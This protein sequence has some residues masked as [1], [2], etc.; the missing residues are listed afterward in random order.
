MPKQSRKISPPRAAAQPRRTARSGRAYPQDTEKTACHKAEAQAIF[1]NAKRM[2][3]MMARTLG[4]FC[5]VAVHDFSDLEHSIIHIEGALTGR[6]V[7]APATNMVTKAWRQG[8][9]NVQD[10][11]AYSAAT[12]SGRTLKSSISFLR[13]SEEQVIGAVCMHFDLTDLERFQGVLHALLR[14][15]S[16]P[17]KEMSEA[18][19]SCLGETS[20]AIIETAIRRAG[21]HPATMTREEKLHF[22]RIMDEEGAF[23]IKGMVQYLAKAMRV[24]I[25]TVYNYM[26]QIKED[27][28][29]EA[30]SGQKKA[31]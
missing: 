24:S 31:D 3:A 15:E 16:A 22:V 19:P 26:R 11:I 2:A 6:N 9:D 13:N 8:G 14:F 4:P 5:E 21:K 29:R 20:D 30:A 27:A 28:S 1:A 23:L 12:P 7:G 10:I 18:F 17:G 25:Y